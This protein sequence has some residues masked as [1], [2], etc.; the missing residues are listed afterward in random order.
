MFS[1]VNSCTNYVPKNVTSLLNATH[2]LYNGDRIRV[3]TLDHYVVLPLTI[4]LV[5]IKNKSLNF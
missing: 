4:R 1:L 5:I 3:H 2:A